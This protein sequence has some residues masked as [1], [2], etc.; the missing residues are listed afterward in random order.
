MMAPETM[1]PLEF[2]QSELNDP[3]SLNEK[4]EIVTVRGLIAEMAP[5]TIRK[6]FDINE[7]Y[8]TSHVQPVT[9]LDRNALKAVAIALLKTSDPHERV[10]SISGGDYSPSELIREVKHETRMGQKIIRGVRLN[11]LLVESA[12]ASGNIKLRP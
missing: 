12:V 5:P 11:G 8:T 3:I 7:R 2:S 6:M 10:T 1:P 9:R 4:G